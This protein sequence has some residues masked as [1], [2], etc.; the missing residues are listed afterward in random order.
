MKMIFIELEQA[1]QYILCHYKLV[2]QNFTLHGISVEQNQEAGSKHKKL[3]KLKKIYIIEQA[4]G[5]SSLNM[6]TKGS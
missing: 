5:L 4:F 3:K 2:L 6:E 1:K